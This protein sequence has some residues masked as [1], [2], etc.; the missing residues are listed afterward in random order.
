MF[1]IDEIMNYYWGSVVQKKGND[2]VQRELS[3]GLKMGKG[4]LHFSYSIPR[5]VYFFFACLVNSHFPPL[6]CERANVSAHDL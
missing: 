1:V 5:S 6:M 2:R 4:R 3:E